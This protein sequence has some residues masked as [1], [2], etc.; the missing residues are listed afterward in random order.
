MHESPRAT[1]R[2]VVWSIHDEKPGHVN[3]LRGLIRAL[4]DRLDIEVHALSPPSVVELA[5]DLL[6]KRF[7]RGEALPRPD[8]ILGAGHATH[9]SILTAGRATGAKTVVLMKPTLPRSWFD[10]CIIPAHDVGVDFRGVARPSKTQGV[11][12]NQS[13]TIITQGVLNAVVPSCVQEEHRGLMLIGGTSNHYEWSSDDILAHVVEIV[14]REPAIAWTLTTSRRTPGEL[15]QQL[16]QLPCANLVVFCG[17]ETSPDWLPAQLRRAARVWVTEDSVSMVYEAL[18]AGGAVGLLPVP[19]K[20]DT[21]VSRGV[22]GL[23]AEGWVTSF[24]AWQTSGTMPRPPGTLSE[25]DRCA[26]VLVERWFAD[27]V[28][29]Q[30]T[31]AQKAA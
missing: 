22:E 1:S 30:H 7:R 19:R 4:G 26:A 6:G 16:Q 2:L 15:V 3:Q 14:A 31:P 13:A 23:L 8:L 11:P 9:L 28:P 29:Q 18:T 17:E 21:R 25:A 20:C 5:F 27:R 10:L 12:P 24:D